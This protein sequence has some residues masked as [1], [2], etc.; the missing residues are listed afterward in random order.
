[1]TSDIGAVEQFFADVDA[2]SATLQ[3]DFGSHPTIGGS[4]LRLRDTQQS[5]VSRQHRRVGHGHVET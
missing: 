4:G 1:V 3:L 5:H 2:L